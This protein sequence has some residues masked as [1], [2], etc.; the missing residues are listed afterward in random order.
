MTHI[1]ESSENSVSLDQAVS[2]EV[3]SEYADDKKF[4]LTDL[5]KHYQKS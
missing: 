2:I 5:P 3:P 4:R 1:T